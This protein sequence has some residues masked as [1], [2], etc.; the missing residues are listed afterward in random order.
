ML[1][2]NVKKIPNNIQHKICKKKIRQVSIFDHKKKI[3]IKTK[4]LSPNKHQ[5]NNQNTIYIY[6][7]RV[8]EKKSNPR[9]NK[10]K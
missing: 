6:R 1:K 7:E 10:I 2:T 3:Q 4:K 9:T 5:Q 8:K